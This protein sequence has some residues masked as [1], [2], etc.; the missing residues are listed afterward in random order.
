MQINDERRNSKYTSER[1]QASTIY[2]M[3][4]FKT[5]IAWETG[6]HNSTRC[7]SSTSGRITSMEPCVQIEEVDE[8]GGPCNGENRGVWHDIGFR[9]LNW[10]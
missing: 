1:G 2:E 4:I 9:E 6:M 7:R 8:G 3:R 10:K 5:G